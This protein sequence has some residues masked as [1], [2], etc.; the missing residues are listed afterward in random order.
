LVWGAAV[1]LVGTAVT[2]HDVGLD[3]AL[4]VVCLSAA[5]LVF[6]F[7]VLIPYVGL[8]IDRIV[9]VWSFLITLV[10]VQ[11]GFELGLLP[12]LAC[13]GLGWLL[14]LLLTATVGRPLMAL[15]RRLWRR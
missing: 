11:H 6:G 15:R 12:A 7:L 8:A 4:R 10:L 5:P 9:H 13:T 14:V 3:T 1:W 2:G